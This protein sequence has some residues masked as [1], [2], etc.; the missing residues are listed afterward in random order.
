[1]IR[2]ILMAGIYDGSVAFAFII[3]TLILVDLLK[4]GILKN[5]RPVAPSEWFVFSAI[6]LPLQMM[7]FG[8]LGAESRMVVDE[9]PAFTSL[10]KYE[11]A[12]PNGEAATVAIETYSSVE[13]RGSSFQYK[14][15]IIN[16]SDT[17]LPLSIK[18]LPPDQ[19]NDKNLTATWNF[20]TQDNVVRTVTNKNGPVTRY[21]QLSVDAGPYSKVISDALVQTYIPGSKR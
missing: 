4:V 17:P 20:T 13:R 7:V 5:A 19:V 10:A 21:F 11:I 1:M 6:L 12:L 8:V 2:A 16:K 9:Y 3:C 18:W 15:R 14:Y